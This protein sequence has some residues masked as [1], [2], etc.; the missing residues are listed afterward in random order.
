MYVHMSCLS[1]LSEKFEFS[2]ERVHGNLFTEHKD[3]DEYTL[4]TCFVFAHRNPAEP[5]KVDY[6]DH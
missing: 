6:V 2:D 4:N 5:R 3:E 1:V